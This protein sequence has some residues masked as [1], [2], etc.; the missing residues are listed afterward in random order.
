MEECTNKLIEIFAQCDTDDLEKNQDYIELCHKNNGIVW[1]DAERKK[2]EKIKKLLEKTVGQQT[3]LK[4][5]VIEALISLNRM[6][7][8]EEKNICYE[9]I[10]KVY[11]NQWQQSQLEHFAKYYDALQK[12]YD[13]FLSFTDRKPPHLNDNYDNVINTK[14]FT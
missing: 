8:E 14:K 4:N 10:T 9:L 12:N 13:Y 2:V 7:T 11:S 1:F 5:Q 3:S 6:R